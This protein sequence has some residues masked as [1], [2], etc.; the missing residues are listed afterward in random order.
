MA[1]KK[2]KKVKKPTTVKKNTQKQSQKQSVH[3]HLGKTASKRK[4]TVNKSTTKPS[5]QP[6]INVQPTV[7][8][9]PSYS[10]ELVGLENK[11]SELAKIV[12]PVKVLQIAKPIKETSSLVEIQ[13]TIDETPVYINPN[14]VDATKK[15]PKNPSESYLPYEPYLNNPYYESSNPK[16]NAD[17][18]ISEGTMGISEPTIARR[19]GRI[20][21]AKTPEELETER[22]MR[23]ARKRELYNQ[24]KMR[25]ENMK[26][27]DDEENN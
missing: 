1:R 19:R 15:L 20:P 10:N 22:L 2:D 24:K 12:K 8:T 21:V 9:M 6:I 17:R 27:E 26:P 5:Q 14:R 23:N 11:I 25:R 3:I 7:Y 16:R 4:P 18:Y 13:K